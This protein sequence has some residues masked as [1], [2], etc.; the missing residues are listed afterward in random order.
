MAED[1]VFT[2]AS[3]AHMPIHCRKTHRY[4]YLPKTMKNRQDLLQPWEMAVTLIWKPPN[5]SLEPLT[6]LTGCRD[7]ASDQNRCA[8]PSDAGR[9][10]DMGPQRRVSPPPGAPIFG[11][12]RDPKLWAPVGILVDEDTLPHVL[13]FT[14][15]GYKNAC[16]RDDGARRKPIRSALHAMIP[17]LS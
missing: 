14:D 11:P 5:S 15:C 17:K 9:S 1:I 7:G 13:T 12:A 4:V 8:T 3:D 2:C 6:A 10:G 16:A